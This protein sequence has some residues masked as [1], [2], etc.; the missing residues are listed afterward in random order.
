MK[1]SELEEFGLIDL[2]AKMVSGSREP[3]LILGIGDD[4]AAWQGD[5]AVQLVTT[6]SL[7][8][9]VHFSLDTTSWEA[10]GW[11]ALAV[12]LSD[13]AAMGGIPR[14]AL[15][16]LALPG[17]VKVDDVTA[18]YRG[19]IKVAQQ[20]DVAIIG[21]D[22]CRASIVS[23]T[24]TVLGTAGD[25][26]QAVLTRSAARPG[27][28]IAV[29]GWLG[30]A[31]G[32]LEMLTGRL[33]FESDMAT[34]LENSFLRPV[35]RVTEGQLLLKQGVKAAIDIS[36]GLVADLNHICQASRVGARVEIEKVPVPPAVKVAFGDKALDMALSGGE[37]YELLFTAP[38]GIIE[39][40]KER[41]SCPVTVIGEIVAE[42]ALGVKLVD[43]D[44]NSVSLA[45]TGWEHF[46]TE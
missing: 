43:A 33:H 17:H 8:Q 38:A 15:I 28:R 16:S 19:I 24:V 42:P 31:A 27:D 6:D 32:G 46:A 4:A 40:I 41:S 3:P 25:D 29:T 13:I 45:T 14:Y 2:L 7:F 37:D 39:K 36:D 30:A 21:G 10:L 5:T 23:I 26:D 18:L 35:P 22:T 20:F 12:N 1:V 44:G 34:S 9:D 11:K